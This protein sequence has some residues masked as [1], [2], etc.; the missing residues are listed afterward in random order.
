MNEFLNAL[1]A[2][3]LD[4]R[5]RALM[6]LLVAGLIGAVAYAALGGGSS[7]PA[8]TAPALTPGTLSRG[9]IAPVAAGANPNQALAETPAGASK[10]RDGATRDPFNPL[11]G[12]SSPAPG[13]AGSKPGTAKGS[14]PTKSGGALFELLSKLAPKPAPKP[15][16]T[17]SV[18]VLMGQ[19]P[20]GTPA[21]SAVLTP[22]QHLKFQQ[23]LP[24]PELRLLS[25]D[26]V[27]GDGKQAKF[28]LIGE[29]IPRGGLAKC[30]PS[31]T[32]CQTIALE[33]SQ[34]EELEYLPPS[35]PAQVYELQVASIASE[36]H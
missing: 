15:T 1:K 4:R 19:V 21:Q 33:V 11:P 3:L 14:T 28:K 12:S 34:S 13:A 2:D 30:S 36:K 18:S 29:L 10:Q 27:S 31:P 17:W 20:A 9:S 6:L 24:S 5:L 22:Y 32:Q 25:F 35:G 23:K 26:G 16:T 8:V 7:A